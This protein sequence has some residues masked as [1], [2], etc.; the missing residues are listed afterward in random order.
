M[1]GLFFV[2]FALIAAAVAAAMVIARIWW[3]SRKLRAQGDMDVIEGSYSIEAESTPAVRAEN[4]ISGTV[5]P[6]PK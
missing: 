5:P 3:V 2:A 6:N 1:I 4:V